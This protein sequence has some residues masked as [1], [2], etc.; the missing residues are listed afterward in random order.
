MSTCGKDLEVNFLN[1]PSVECFRSSILAAEWFCADWSKNQQSAKCPS[2]S[3]KVYHSTIFVNHTIHGVKGY[4]IIFPTHLV[5]CHLNIPSW[6]YD[7]NMED[8]SEDQKTCGD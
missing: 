5:P 1:L 8:H 7:R 6:S 3:E 2:S 4:Q